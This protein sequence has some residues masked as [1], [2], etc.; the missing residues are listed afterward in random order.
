MTHNHSC[1]RC[2]KAFTC[3]ATDCS[4]DDLCYECLRAE[5]ASLRGVVRPLMARLGVN[6]M[7]QVLPTVSAVMAE[8]D[9]LKAFVIKISNLPVPQ[10]RATD[11]RDCWQCERNKEDA[12]KL[13]E[14]KL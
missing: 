4:D 2:R 6:Y 11:L 9:G 14:G 12:E 10:H 7:G 8:R 5:L 3:S 13:L 1:P